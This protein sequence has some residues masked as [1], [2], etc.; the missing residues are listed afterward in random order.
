MRI[1]EFV[2]VARKRKLDQAIVCGEANLLALTGIRCDNGIL[3]VRRTTTGRFAVAFYTDFRYVPMVH[4]VAPQLRCR[5]IKSFRLAGSRIGIE[6]SISH[7]RYLSLA[8]AAPRKAKFVD[9]TNDLAEIRMVKTPEEI[10][11]LRD[12]ERLVCEIWNDAS[13]RFEPGMSERQMAAIIKKMMIDLGDGE[14][15]ATIVCVGKNA[16][17]CHHEPDDTVWNGREPVLVDLGVRLNGV[18]SDLTRNLVPGLGSPE[19]LS[20]T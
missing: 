17:E 7:A 14:A 12:A 20:W 5:D 18:C 1:E 19:S 11:K 10:A 16:A 13:R 2:S 8:K 15:F 3:E 9:L 4:R 6:Y